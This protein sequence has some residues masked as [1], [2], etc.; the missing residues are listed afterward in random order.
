MYTDQELA[1]KMQSLLISY[2]FPKPNPREEDLMTQFLKEN[3]EI[4]VR[5]K[6]LSRQI[7]ENALKAK[8]KDYWKAISQWL[9][10]NNSSISNITGRNQPQRQG[11][12]ATTTSDKIMY[13]D[14]IY[15]T[16]LSLN[17]SSFSVCKAI[18][19]QLR[20]IKHFI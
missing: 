15:Q 1:K 2:V 9:K 20:F 7:T 4:D 18:S 13:D 3:T 8:F 19:N 6:L 16:N 17:Q 14:A 10:N 11:G 5:N 12:N